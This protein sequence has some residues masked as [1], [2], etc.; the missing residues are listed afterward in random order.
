MYL[1]L[2]S[3]ILK[4]LHHTFYI[5]GLHLLPTQKQK[6]VT[7]SPS[8]H[9]L[10]GCGFKYFLFSSVFGEDYHFDEHIFQRG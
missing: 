6:P 10:L 4:T 3:L 2:P 7:F 1:F 8:S 5:P 9:D